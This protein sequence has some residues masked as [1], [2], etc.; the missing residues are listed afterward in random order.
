M[1]E[2]TTPATPAAESLNGRPAAD[3]V[4]LPVL[5][6]QARIGSELREI[7]ALRVRIEVDTARQTLQGVERNERLTV[8]RVPRGVAVTEPRPPWTEDDVLVVPVYA[9]RLELQRTLVL[10]EEIRIARQALRHPVETEAV[11]RRERAVVERRQPDGS[12]REV[13]VEAGSTVES[14]PQRTERNEP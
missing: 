12:W 9:E 5:A 2:L 14:S 1:H 6:E 13:A 10:T 4:V 3:E 8:Q 7:G 11:L